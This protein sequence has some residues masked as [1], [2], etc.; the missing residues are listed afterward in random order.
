[1]SLKNGSFKTSDLS[2]VPNFSD[3]KR[4]LLNLDHELQY[5]G[6]SGVSETVSHYD[7]TAI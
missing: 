4:F 6:T 3:H 7:I 5:W 1:M 2:Q